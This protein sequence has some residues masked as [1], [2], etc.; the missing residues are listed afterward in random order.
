LTIFEQEEIEKILKAGKIVRAVREAAPKLVFEGA[1]AIDIC[2]GV[3]AEVRRLGG[4]P[5]F[6]CNVSIDEVGA[7]YTSPPGDRTVIP[8]MSLV[9]VDI[10]AHIDGF[11]ADS[12]VTVSV[13]SEHEEMIGVAEEALARAIHAVKINGPISDVGAVVEKYVRS[14]GFRP[15]RNLTGHQIAPYT[16]HAGVSIPNVSEG[17]GGFGGRF[18][19]WSIYALEPFVTL[20]DA[21]GIIQEGRLGNILHLAKLKKP[22]DAGQRA[23]FEHIYGSYRTLPFARRW[24][25]GKPGAELAEAMLAG[26]A[27]YE[28][29]TLVEASHKPIAQAEHTLLT[30]DREVLII[31]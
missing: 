11:L 18:Q 14:M 16:V 1:K 31:T 12:A 13:G 23:L 3:E 29:P 20:P 19:P 10:G 22:K 2:N 26:R 27:L 7:H 30:T 24:L 25:D 8:P 5:A 6:P 21:R 4:K 17:L 15:I 9:K 28:Y